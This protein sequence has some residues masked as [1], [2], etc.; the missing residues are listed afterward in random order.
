MKYKNLKEV[1]EARI[2]MPQTNILLVK[3]LS[4]KDCPICV[5]Y[6]ALV[7]KNKWGD[8]GCSICPLNNLLVQRKRKRG[9]CIEWII[10]RCRRD[11]AKII[12]DLK[13]LLAIVEKEGIEA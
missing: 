7:G 4:I 11:P 6:D 10:K 5:F 13:D 1:I 9:D 12:S 3:L 2:Q 8:T